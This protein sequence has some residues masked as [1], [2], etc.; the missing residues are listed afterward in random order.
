[1][2][3][4]KVLQVEILKC[5][6]GID[7]FETEMF[8]M[9]LDMKFLRMK[10]ELCTDDTQRSPFQNAHEAK[11]KQMQNMEENLVFFKERLEFF[12]KEQERVNQ[13]N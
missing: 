5:E 10:L 2:D 11:K 12:K 1:M 13:T 7:N 6:D 4:S 3:A 8:K 9:S